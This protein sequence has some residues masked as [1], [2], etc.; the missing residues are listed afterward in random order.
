MI[1]QA[2]TV[3]GERTTH[4]IF[5]AL[6]HRLPLYLGHGPIL[7]TPG[8]V[9]VGVLIR[10]TEVRLTFDGQA[11]LAGVLEYSESTKP[12]SIQV[13]PA[14]SSCG[15][16]ISDFFGRQ[17]RSDYWVTNSRKWFSLP[18]TSRNK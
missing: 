4:V 9:I 5:E 10:A 2:F 8:T 14:L 12:M 1:I 11:K 16:T 7:L 15:T 17:F 13:W 18:I 6:D 3:Y